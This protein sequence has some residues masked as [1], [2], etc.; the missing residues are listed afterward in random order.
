MS[1]LRRGNL[2]WE[3]SRMMLP[4]H[5][6]EIL[7]H[8]QELARKT[9]PEFDEQRLEELSQTL[10]GACRSQSRVCITLY[11]PFASPAVTGRIAK[12]DLPGGR[13]KLEEDGQ[14][15]WIPL[16]DITDISSAEE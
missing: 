3:A 16:A 8:R 4:E 5:K 14:S 7:N 12:V 11:D 15:L 6:E 2:L 13:V 10:A 1:E 9:R